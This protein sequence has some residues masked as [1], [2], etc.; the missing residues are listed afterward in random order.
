L[1]DDGG[2]PITNYEYSLDGGQ[3]WIALNP[4]QTTSPVR[5]T[6]LDNGTE[7][8]IILRA[9]NENGAGA[10]SE[11]VKVTPGEDEDNNNSTDT[12][13]APTNLEATP[14]DGE[15]EISFDLDDDGGSSITNYEY[16]LDG[17]Q[18]WIAFNPAQTTSPV[19]ITGLD[20]GTEYTIILRAI[21][22]NGAGAAS[23][24]VKVTP[25]EDEDN[26]STDTPSAPIN[27]EATPGDG[28]VEIS[29]D[30]DDD[31]GSP[32]TNY[33]YSLDGGQTWIAFN[34]AQTTSPVTIT[35]LD[36]GTEYTIIL[37]A[38]NENGA[39]AASESVKVTP[40]EDEDNNS[41][42]TPS[43]PINLEANPGDGEVEISFDLG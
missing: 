35:G 13:S 36:N 20:N 34:P 17:G 38:I 2:S 31:G 6:G 19:T 11:S 9:I 22:E 21:N 7:Y 39:G 40:G 23:E 3:T 41:T 15:V 43:A 1:D 30:L 37:R 24:S 5:I 14:G 8:T 26:N 4:A 32:I 28:Q 18:T 42:D 33:E 29:F 27:L 10:A 25:G 12:P 16:S